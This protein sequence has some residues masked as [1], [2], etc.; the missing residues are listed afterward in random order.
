[1]L[2]AGAIQ[3]LLNQTRSLE[4]NTAIFRPGQIIT[5]KADKLYPDGLAVIQVG[6]QKVTAKLETGLSVGQR[7]WFQVQPG[8]GKVHLKMLVPDNKRKPDEEGIAGLLLKLSIP[9]TR[10]NI[11]MARYFIKERLPLTKEV[12]VK[13]AELTKG[14]KAGEVLEILKFLLLRGIT[15]TK[16]ILT[17]L[18][19]AR[20]GHPLPSLIESLDNALEAYSEDSET[21]LELKKVLR[22]LKESGRSG[23]NEENGTSKPGHINE[24]RIK[25]FLTKLGLNYESRVS[26]VLNSSSGPAEPVEAVKPLLLKLLSE[27]PLQP[28]KDA[29]EQLVGKI[30][31]LQLLSQESGPVQQLVFQIPFSPSANGE[32]TMQWSG[33][34]QP[35]GSIDPDYCRVLFYLELK[36]LNHT[37]VDLQIQNRILSVHVINENEELKKLALPLIGT[38]KARIAKIGYQLSAV[39]FVKPKEACVQ[40]ATKQMGDFAHRNKYSRM[41]LRI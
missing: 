20:N 5:G 4:G 33:K 39:S 19:I 10:E 13:A 18:Q 1:M 8:N 41:D 6:S 16:D 7:Y 28:L 22:D 36:E 3:A 9:S 32:I 37:I 40:H 23:F 21:I 17:A 12:L 29:A 15:P 27:N 38:L 24:E 11:E 35:D 30:T 14:D 2:E 25:Q 26:E 34:K 31:G